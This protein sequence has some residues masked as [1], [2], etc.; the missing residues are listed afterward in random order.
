MALACGFLVE[1]GAFSLLG[2]FVFVC[3]P[4]AWEGS[5]WSSWSP[6][7]DDRGED[8][9]AGGRRAAVENEGEEASR[10]FTGTVV[11]IPGGS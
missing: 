6:A 5:S 8:E 4:A 1:A 7:R 3:E 10:I 11:D 2:F 9:R